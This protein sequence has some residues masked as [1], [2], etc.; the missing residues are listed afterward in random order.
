M[1]CHDAETLLQLERDGAL[2]AGGRASLA[3]HVSEC[4]HCRQLQVKLTAVSQVLQ[5]EAAHVRTPEPM[6]EWRKLQRT[7]HQESRP[8]LAGWLRWL[9]IPAAIG[10]AAA[11]ALYVQPGSNPEPQPKERVVRVEAVRE[12]S[13]IVYVDDRSGWTFVWSPVPAASGQ[14][15]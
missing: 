12:P 11:L 7:L 13:A 8:A 15:I 10:A 6:I 14:T 4:A 1:N 3:A 5:Q 2:E 9:T